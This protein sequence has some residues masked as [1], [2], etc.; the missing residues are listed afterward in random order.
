MT[1]L[2]VDDDPLLRLIV[3][4]ALQ[5]K[6]FGTTEASDGIEDYKPIQEIGDSIGSLLTDTNVTR[7]GFSLALSA[8]EENSGML[9]LF[10]TGQPSHLLDVRTS[11]SVLE[12]PVLLHDLIRAVRS[13]QA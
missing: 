4:D 5:E 10:M 2:V 13:V 3:R 11:S 1:I 9:I 7:I 12:K 6:G 8:A